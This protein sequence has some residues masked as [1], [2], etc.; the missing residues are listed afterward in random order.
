MVLRPKP[1]HPTETETKL[2]VMGNPLGMP[3]RQQQFDVFGKPS[4][5]PS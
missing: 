1:I 2:T 4:R 3:W 5:L